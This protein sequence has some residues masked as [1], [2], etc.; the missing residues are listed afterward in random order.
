[1]SDHSPDEKEVGNMLNYFRLLLISKPGTDKHVA[2]IKVNIKTRAAISIIQTQ[3]LQE[4][5]GL[6]QS[7]HHM[8]VKSGPIF[9]SQCKALTKSNHS[10]YLF[11]HL[12]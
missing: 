5:R 9:R 12:K 2:D 10:I 6:I 3:V 8:A 4:N 1:M 7:S 11:K